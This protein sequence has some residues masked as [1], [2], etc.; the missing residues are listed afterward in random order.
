LG[1]TFAHE[2]YLVELTSARDQL[3]AALSGTAPEPGAKP[4]PPAHEIA[5][6]I[7]SPESRPQH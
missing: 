2:A 7:K 6:R 5:D 3:K 1:K 4:L